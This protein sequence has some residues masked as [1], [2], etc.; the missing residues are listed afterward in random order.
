MKA[1]P[2]SVRSAAGSPP[3]FL[4][5]RPARRCWDG[6][7][8]RKDGGEPR[9]QR[10]DIERPAREF[11]PLVRRAADWV[12]RDVP[13]PG[14]VARAPVDWMLPARASCFSPCPEARVLLRYDGASEGQDQP[15]FGLVRRRRE[16]RV[17]G[18]TRAGK[19]VRGLVDC[20]A[21]V[22]EVEDESEHVLHVRECASADE[23]REREPGDAFLRERGLGV[24]NEARDE[25]VPWE[26]IAP[27]E[28][29]RARRPE[30][31]DDGLRRREHAPGGAHRDP[32]SP[33]K[34]RSRKL[35][36]SRARVESFLAFILHPSEG[37]I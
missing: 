18:A 12:A 19:E 13:E 27:A 34:D 24:G 2:S 35:F 16:R 30:G 33:L 23:G 3:S 17:D 9:Q 21:A 32:P 8:P 11:C 22:V 4:C 20:R 1:R 31:D 36:P 14:R 10:L 15:E 5:R 29:V 28:G 25:G 37:G 26:P 7:L 6:L